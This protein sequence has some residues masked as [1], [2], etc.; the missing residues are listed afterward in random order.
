MMNEHVLV[1]RRAMSLLSTAVLLLAGSCAGSDPDA[2]LLFGLSPLDE[3]G[4]PLRR[5]LLEGARSL[6][7]GNAQGA[8]SVLPVTGLSNGSG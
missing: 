1:L 7:P 6:S 8:G 3:R 4:K 2:G 5:P